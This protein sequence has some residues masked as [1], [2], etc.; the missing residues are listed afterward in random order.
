M[1]NPGPSFA[2]EIFWAAEFK[3]GLES[4]GDDGRSGTPKTATTEENIAKV[5]QMVV[6]DSRI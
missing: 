3:H 5:H 4:L 2:T 6:D 1:V